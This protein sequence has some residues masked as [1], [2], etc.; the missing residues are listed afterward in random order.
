[1]KHFKSNIFLCSLAAPVLQSKKLFGILMLVWNGS[2]ER[3]LINHYSHSYGN[4]P[5]AA[6]CDSENDTGQPSISLRWQYGHPSVT[7]LGAFAHLLR[8]NWSKHHTVVF[9]MNFYSPLSLSDD[10]SAKAVIRPGTPHLMRA[11][12]RQDALLTFSS[13]TKCGSLRLEQWKSVMK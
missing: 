6:Q 4:F 3:H 5:L 1:M 2:S 12:S 11:L 9:R 13:A 10:S 8:F 7:R